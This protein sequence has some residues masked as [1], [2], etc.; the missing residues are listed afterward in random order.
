MEDFWH[1]F[2]Y[3]FD[4]FE[5]VVKTTFWVG[6]LLAGFLQ[7]DGGYLGIAGAFGVASAV[8]FWL[9]GYESAAVLIGVGCLSLTMVIAGVLLRRRHERKRRLRRE[10]QKQFLHEFEAARQ[11]ENPDDPFWQEFKSRT[12]EEDSNDPFGQAFEEEDSND[13]FQQ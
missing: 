10:Q 3:N 5:A 6:L 2:R 4:F 12:E 1:T 11:Q 13:P 8:T 9:F 7:G